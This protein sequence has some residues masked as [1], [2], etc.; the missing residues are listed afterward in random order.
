VTVVLVATG[1]T[2]FA[3]SSGGGFGSSSPVGARGSSLPGSGGGGGS[4]IG[5]AKAT[6]GNRASNNERDLIAAF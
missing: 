2:V 3:G 5:C 4:G 6:L 1:A